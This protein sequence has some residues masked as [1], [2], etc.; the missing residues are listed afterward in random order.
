MKGKTQLMPNNTLLCKI[1]SYLNNFE[2]ADCSENRNLFV[3][4]KSAGLFRDF[5][6]KPPQKR[7]SYRSLSNLKNIHGVYFFCDLS[8]EKIYYVGEAHTQTLYKRITQHLCNSDT[9][10]LRHKFSSNTQIMEDLGNSEIYYIE[11]KT[12]N[13]K[14]ILY[15]ESLLIGAFKP[16]LNFEPKQD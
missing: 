13:I 2:N 3:S 16:Y 7:N 14:Q 10:G 1:I 5:I 15:L 12:G 11:L 4:P 6:P 8:K 9:G